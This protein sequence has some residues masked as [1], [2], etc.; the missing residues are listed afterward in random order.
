[1]QLAFDKVAEIWKFWQNFI[2]TTV[3]WCGRQILKKKKNSRKEKILFQL[4]FVVVLCYLVLQF[5]TPTS[6]D[7]KYKGHQIIYM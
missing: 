4:N 1:M 6:M 5:V 3:H 2:D 7:F